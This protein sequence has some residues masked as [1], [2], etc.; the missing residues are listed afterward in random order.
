ME[1]HDPH[2]HTAADIFG[3][4]VSEVTPEQRHAA[5]ALNFWLNY[6]RMG[7]PQEHKS[8]VDTGRVEAM[9]ES[10]RRMY[11]GVKMFPDMD[12]GVTERR[13]I[14]DLDHTLAEDMTTALRPLSV[15]I[16][17]SDLAP[18]APATNLRTVTG[19]IRR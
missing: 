9:Y 18:P 14:T 10:Y 6:G 17:L 7:Y 8:F 15:G 12:Y 13:I 11:G 5:K 3:C 4:A 2:R 1:G 16:A 19:R